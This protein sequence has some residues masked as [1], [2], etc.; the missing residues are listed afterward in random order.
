MPDGN[1]LNFDTNLPSDQSSV[2]EGAAQIR[3]L[4]TALRNWSGNNGEVAG[5][6]FSANTAVATLTPHM[7]ITSSSNQNGCGSPYG[8]RI[9]PGRFMSWS[10]TRLPY[11]A[12]IHST[13][14]ARS[15]SL[16]LSLGGIGIGPH[17][18][19]PPARILSISLACAAVSPAYF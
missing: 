1:G 4:R 5:S 8:C 12:S 15:A 7:S 3:A 17:T 10:V 2:K 18:P 19:L 16:T 6:I 11:I 9:L 13:S 14:T